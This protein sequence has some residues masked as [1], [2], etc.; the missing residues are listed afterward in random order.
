MSSHRLQGP[1]PTFSPTALY[2]L[3][4][5]ALGPNRT[6]QIDPSSGPA[7]LL[8]TAPLPAAAAP[9]AFRVTPAHDADRAF[10]NLCATVHT[11]STGGGGGR[12]LC[13]DVFGD[14]KATPHLAAPAGVSGQLWT[15]AGWGDGTWRLTN[16]YSGPDLRLDSKEGAGNGTL[17]RGE[18][19]GQHWNF[20]AL[21]ERPENGNGS[22]GAGGPRGY[23]DGGSN[24]TAVFA[25]PTVRTFF[26]DARWMRDLTVAG[27]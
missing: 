20:T 3:A 1:P 19:K 7:I 27:L 25:G 4:N 6:L 9:L 13:L 18:R 12:S 23:V 24:G 8:H 10:W 22:G 2:T 14:D 15:I 21:A 26:F 11:V 5:S 17:T 16:E